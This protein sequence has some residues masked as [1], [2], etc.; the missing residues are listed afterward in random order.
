LK[1]IQF[2]ST[3]AY[4]TNEI[5]NAKCGVSVIYVGYKNTKVEPQMSYGEC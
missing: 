4:Y 1:Y 2:D 3:Q 5:Q